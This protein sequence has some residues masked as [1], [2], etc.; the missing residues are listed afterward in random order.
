MNT[1]ISPQPVS[2]L[3]S[4]RRWF[5]MAFARWTERIDSTAMPTHHRMGSWEASTRGKRR[6]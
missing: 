2:L 5:A 3:P 6:E 4:V 1:R